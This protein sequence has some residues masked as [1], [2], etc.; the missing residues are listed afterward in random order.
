MN[1]G[2][3]SS[4]RCCMSF[5][6]A[7]I[8]TEPGSNGQTGALF[9]GLIVSADSTTALK[10]GTPK[11]GACVQ[12]A[13]RNQAELRACDLDSAL[14]ADHQAGAVWAFVQSLDLQA[15]Y[16]RTRPTVRQLRHLPVAVRWGGVGVNHH[17]LG[18]F[19]LAPTCRHRTETT[20]GA[21][22]PG[23]GRDR[24]ILVGQGQ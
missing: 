23:D 7:S 13:V 1:V 19:R 16:T 14:P 8:T 4:Q 9:E 17:T 22:P 21:R 24:Q 15:L 6:M 20:H 18:D 11:R 3:P 12:S 5:G 10:R 2:I